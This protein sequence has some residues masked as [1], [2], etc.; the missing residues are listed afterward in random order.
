MDYILLQG[1]EAETVKNYMPEDVL[2]GF[3]GNASRYALCALDGD[4]VVGAAVF[5]A[6]LA[7]KILSIRTSEDCR[8]AADSELLGNIL[9]MCENLGCEGVYYTIYDEDDPAFWE[10]ILD[11]AGFV[12]Q[13][14]DELFGIPL[15]DLEFNATL[16]KV[17][18]SNNVA[19]LSMASRRPS[20]PTETGWRPAVHMTSSVWAAF[21]RS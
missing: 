10:P 16:D 9:T 12:C 4:K 8:G 7:A 21:T 2:D 13:E 17:T 18:V 3:K 20:K 14:R 11:E 5:D 6:F 15:I 1:E 19:S